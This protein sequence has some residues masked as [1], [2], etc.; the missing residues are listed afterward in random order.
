M[1]EGVAVLCSLYKSDPDLVA[2]EEDVDGG[3]RGS[4]T[5]IIFLSYNLL[6]KKMIN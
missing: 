5:T 3:R 6:L 2:S 4:K 1:T